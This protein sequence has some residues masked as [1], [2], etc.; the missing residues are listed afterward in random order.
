MAVFD[1]QTPQGTAD[2][3][4]H[5]HD[6]FTTDVLQ[7]NTTIR[8]WGFA[9]EGKPREHTSGDNV[10]IPVGT[11]LAV[12]TATLDEKSDPA[13][14]VAGDAPVLIPCNPYGD[15]LLVTEKAVEDKD[16]D[17]LLGLSRDLAE[18]AVKKQD[19]IAGTACIGGTEQFIK[20]SRV[21]V[22]ALLAGDVIDATDF[23]R[24][25]TILVRNKVPRYADGFFRAFISANQIGDLFSD[26][27][28]VTGLIEQIKY[29]NPQALITAEIGTWHGFRIY[30]TGQVSTTEL[31]AATASAD[32]E[33][34]MFMGR[35]YIGYTERR[36]ISFGGFKP[37]GD[38]ME[39]VYKAI[40]KARYGYGR[41]KEE[42]G[43]RMLFRS[44]LAENP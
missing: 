43:L 10:S 6:T 7:A 2:L 25:R 20:N 41:V 8:S 17:T 5:I 15:Y 12:T 11:A 4:T 16:M 33:N 39:Q 9:Y 21:D 23:T 44:A 38:I 27:T 31:G 37:A 34:A 1:P 36:P 19:L 3:T 13:P 42:N 14:L 32:L 35:D 40:W 24:A 29:A 30:E 28:N 26:A 18:H 22:N